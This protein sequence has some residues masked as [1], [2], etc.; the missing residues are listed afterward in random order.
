MLRKCANLMPYYGAIF[1]EEI[2]DF[3][4]WIIPKDNYILLGSALKPKE[5][6]WEK[7]ELLKVKLR[8]LIMK[9]DFQS[10]L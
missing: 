2:T 4:S 1:D 3:Y 5:N 6:T 7:F 8:Y 9:S 10:I